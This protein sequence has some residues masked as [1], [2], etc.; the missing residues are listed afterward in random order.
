MEQ[1]ATSFTRSAASTANNYGAM[2]AQAEELESVF[3]NTLVGQMFSSI[4]TNGDF[5]GGYGE[6]TWRS[7]QSEQFA[8]SISR[9]GGVGLADQIMQNLIAAQET[10]QNA[11][12][13]SATS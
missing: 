6:E 8:A 5:G 4:D 9:S 12:I 10:A 7:M 3:I 1:L 13:N 11:P 2:R